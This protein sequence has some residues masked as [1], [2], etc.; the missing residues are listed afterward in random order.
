MLA[1]ITPRTKLAFIATPNNPTGTMTTRQ[2]LDGWF[3]RVPDHVLTVIDQAYFEYVE[4]PDYPDAIA[5]YARSG[6]RVLVLRTFSKIYGL[7]S[8]RVGYGVAPEP[9]ITA[10]GKVRRAFD[11]TSAAQEAALAS[12]VDEAEVARRRVANRQS[13]TALEDTLRRN[14]FDPVTP[15]VANFFFVDTGED[16]REL[17]EALMHRGVIVRPMGPFGAPQAL[18][19]TAGTLDEIAFLAEQLAHVAPAR[20]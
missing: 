6:R 12:L 3:E 5:D 16:A 2:E 15:A 7:A 19:I 13:M 9:L 20:A 17:N 4:D 18:R 1:A 10:I 8:L 11:V 14:G